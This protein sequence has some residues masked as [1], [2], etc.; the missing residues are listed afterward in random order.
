VLINEIKSMKQ[1]ITEK[2]L[3]VFLKERFANYTI[4]S[5]TLLIEGKRYKPD[6]FIEELNLIVEF[7]GPR[8]YTTPATCVRDVNRRLVFDKH[9]YKTAILPYYI[10]LDDMSIQFVFDS[11]IDKISS[12]KK[13]NDYPHGFISP[14]VILPAEFCSLGL[15]RFNNE[16]NRGR[17]RYFKNEIIRSL[18]EK[19]E[20][21]KHEFEVYPWT[22]G[23]N[24]NF[25][26]N[27]KTEMIAAMQGGQEFLDSLDLTCPH[28]GCNCKLEIH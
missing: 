10:Q 7:D 19:I 18:D 11:V 27:D 12:R 15:Y 1:Y 26:L 20:S 9:G 16:I 3:G 4:T 14:N 5:P 21:G 22:E 2:I 8:H 13:F 28:E 6:F 24:F 25:E 23:L 17:F